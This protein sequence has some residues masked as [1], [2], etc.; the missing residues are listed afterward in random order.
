M[1][2]EGGS[3]G[4]S[5]GARQ[6]S[7]TRLDANGDVTIR[8]IMMITDRG[9]ARG[10]RYSIDGFPQ[11]DRGTLHAV[12]DSRVRH[13]FGH[14]TVSSARG[15]QRTTSARVRRALQASS[16]RTAVWCLGRCGRLMRRV[17]LTMLLEDR[18]HRDGGELGGWHAARGAQVGGSEEEWTAERAQEARGGGAREAGL[19]S[20]RSSGDAVRYDG[21]R[22]LLKCST[23]PRLLSV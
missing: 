14:P 23:A 3:H 17:R 15:T 11:V 12:A 4:R 2:V 21:Q 5:R 7:Y 20:W 6:N 22:W 8:S 18:G 1:G 13:W 19:A 10:C 16:N 9:G